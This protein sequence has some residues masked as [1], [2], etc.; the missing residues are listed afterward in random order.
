MEKRERLI[1]P[2]EVSELIA[3]VLALEERDRLDV[4]ARRSLDREIGAPETGQPGWPV[5]RRWLEAAPSDALRR[6]IDHLRSALSMLGLLLAALGFFLGWAAAAA[7]LSIEVHTGRINIVLAFAVLVLLPLLSVIVSLG[8]FVWTALAPTRSPAIGFRTLLSGFGLTRLAMRLLPASVRSDVSNVLGRM[9]AH[10]RLY[11]RVE[12]GQFLRWSQS[13]GLGFAAGALVATLAFVAF[14]DLA[15]GW[16][17][18]LAIEARAVYLWVHHL[19]LPWASI[20]PEASPSLD[21]VET[22]RFFRVAAEE[23]THLIDPILFGGWW[24]FLVASIVTY[25]LL[26][27]VLLLLGVRLWHARAVGRAIGLTPGVDRLLERLATPMIEGQAEDPELEIG[28]GASGLVPTVDLRNW[29]ERDAGTAP[30]ALRWAA[31]PGDDALSSVLGVEGIRVEDVGGRRS[32]AE[33][34][35]AIA[36]LTPR[37]GGVAFC[38]RAH[39][40]PVLDVLDTLEKVRERL[41]PEPSML[42]ALVGGN[43]RNAET[44]R[45]KLTELGDPRIVTAHVAMESETVHA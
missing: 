42:V 7:L 6:R 27:R 36:R 24:P 4:R 17:S 14:T 34:A 3:T 13:V 5:L 20:W 18:T 44:W 38:V 25:A 8:V 31:L 39:E 40:P 28:H 26:P 30:I 37:D 2:A 23:H 12:R 21:L 15:F 45:R 16:S 9:T 10:G 19:A 32:L 35:S 33:D 43:Q 22:T 11:G 29:F 41:G 1:G